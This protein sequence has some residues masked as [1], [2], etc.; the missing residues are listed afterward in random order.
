M[1]NHRPLL[2]QVAYYH[3]QLVYVYSSFYFRMSFN[4]LIWINTQLLASL[5]CWAV[6][7]GEV[8]DW[9]G[10]DAFRV[11]RTI[12][13]A[14]KRSLDFNFDHNW[15][16]SLLEK[17]SGWAHHC[18]P[19]CSTVLSASSSPFSLCF[20]VRSE[21]RNMPHR[22]IKDDWGKSACIRNV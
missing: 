6:T 16:N 20:Y 12:T 15:N 10:T 3:L 14:Q 19:R 1:T 21:R 11:R 4:S 17:L 8:H 5:I 9:W 18:P 22:F 2:F 13:W 7:W